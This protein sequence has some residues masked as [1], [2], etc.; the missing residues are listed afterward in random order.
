MFV[1]HHRE[2]LINATIFFV[3]KTRHC[4]TLKLNKLMNFLDF[5]HY[6][7]T[8]R[9][10]TGFEYNALAMGPA[11][12]KLLDELKTPTTDFAAAINT[13][14]VRGEFSDRI[15]RRD[16]K[17]KAEFDKSWFTKR[18]ID[19]MERLAEYFAE[20]DGGTMSAFSHDR[21]LPWFKVYR[22]GA[23]ENQPIP[24]ELA[25]DAPIIADMPSLPRDEIL[26]R[27]EEFA[28]IDRAMVP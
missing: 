6:R 15:M 11:S 9:S 25:L 21:K 2:K 24:Y 4:H 14:D 8:G 20:A 17:A 16:L 26:A 12:F 23:G 3:A 13:L 10:V 7:Q 28:A 22:N 18:E 19:I 5:E 27:Q 1:S